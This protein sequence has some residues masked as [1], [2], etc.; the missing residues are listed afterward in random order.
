MRWILQRLRGD[1]VIWIV[2][3][4]LALVSL[5]A[6]YSASSALSF[7]LRGG[8]TEYFLLKHLVLLLLGFVVMFA[9]HLV[10]YRFF[11][12]IS[13][14]L[15]FIT[16]SLLIYTIV[17]GSELNEAARWITIFG[18]S[19]QP[20]D[21]AKITLVIYLARLLTQRQDVIKDF[22]EGFLPAL[23]WVTVICG[24]IAP[25]DLSTA[26]LMFIA[27]VLVMFVAGVDMKYVGILVLVALMGLMILTR[28][29]KRSGTWQSRWSDYTERITNPEYDGSFQ[30]VTSHIAIASGGLFGKGVGKSTQRNFLPH[31][32]ADFVFAII[33][34]E[35]GLVGAGVVIALYLLLLFRSV[36]IVTVSKTFGALLACGLSSLLVLQAVMNMGVTV[37]LLP[38]TGLTL[39][40]ISMGGTSILTTGVSIG[41]I[42]SVSREAIERK[43]DKRV[44]QKQPRF[45]VA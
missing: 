7:R 2:A 16:I 33:V 17:Q 22:T 21:L 6:V 23:F 40:I 26:G 29:A 3:I 45:S 35:F 18:Q 24:L 38:V 9:T 11:A 37:G 8:D 28:T 34:E 12:R 36:I 27:S 25:S 20:S 5:L 15:L 14:A 32:H 31:A 42:L 4:L 10:D 30:I 39:P 44:V 41:I 13:N 43:T 19:F 1:K